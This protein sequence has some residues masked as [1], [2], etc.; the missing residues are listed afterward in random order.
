MSKAI[1]YRIRDGVRKKK[2]SLAKIFL[3]TFVVALG[4]IGIFQLSIVEATNWYQDPQ[5]SLTIIKNAI[6]NDS[7]NFSFTTNGPGLSNFSL[8]DDSDNTLSN[9]RTFTGLSSGTYS[10]VESAVAG[11][12]QTSATC[13]DGS[14]VNAINLSADEDVT[15]TFTN[16]KRGQL[17]KLTVTKVVIIDNGGTKVVSDFP[18]FVDGNPVTSGTQNTSTVGDHVVTETGDPNYAA[19]FSGD[20]DTN[21]N[22]T[23]NAG[24]VKAC[25]I[26][27]N[28]NAPSLTLNKVVANDNGGSAIESAWTL[29]ASG[30]TGFSGP[31]PSV[32]NGASFDA[33]TYNLSEAGG[34]AGYS[35]SGWVCVGVTQDDS[36][37]VT[38]G[39]G[40][41]A[42]CT[43]TNN[44]NAPSLTLNKVVAPAS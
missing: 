40:Q 39:L 4:A 43:I 33:G 38:L 5:G 12:D 30:P 7:Q 34:P 29:S 42:T 11:W 25:T 23:L 21:G 35:A 17:P 3:P 36:D 8:D 18:L 16:T 41:S 10:V 19:S 28:D 24:D 44:D 1:V 22:V 31:G 14:P 20:C 9:T 2:H 26:T 37:T 27:N 15:C 32:S 13:S 6:P